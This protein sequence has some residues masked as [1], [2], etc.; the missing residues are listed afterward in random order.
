MKKFSRLGTFTLTLAIVILCILPAAQAVDFKISGQV[1]RAVL[2]G[3]NGND[4]DT[5]FVDNYNS[6]TRF[7]FAGSNNFNEVWTAGILWEVEMQSNPS[8]STVIDIGRNDD[9][10]DVTFKERKI[11]FYVAHKN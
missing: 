4:D 10:T 3:D 11:E 5:K 8:N 6:S 9:S 7:R 2:W 1:N